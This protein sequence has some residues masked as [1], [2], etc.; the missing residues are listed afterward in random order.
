MATI[1]PFKGKMCIRD[2]ITRAFLFFAYPTKMSGDA[3]WVS[4]DSIFGLG[5]TVDG[6][7]A[8]SYTHLVPFSMHVSGFKYREIAARLG[9]PLGTVKRRIF[10]TRQKLQEALKDFI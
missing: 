10:F 6:L 8:V 5:Q 9:L 4:G 2:R 3:V 1:K 7:T